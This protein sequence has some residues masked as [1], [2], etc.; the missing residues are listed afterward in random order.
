MTDST[1]SLKTALSPLPTWYLANARRLPWREDTQPYHVWLSEIML[2]QTRVEAVTGYYRRFLAALPTVA[3]LAAV[4]DDMLMK[5]WEGLGYYSRARNLKKAAGV[6]INELGGSFPDTYEGI[7]ALPGVGPYT[8][9]AI[10]SICFGLPEP[11]VDGNVLRVFSRLTEYGENIDTDAAKKQV[12]EAL[13]PCYEAGSCGALTQSLM[14]LGATVCIPN[15][16]PKCGV[17]PVKERCAAYKNGTWDRF[18][19]RGEKKQRKIIYKTVLLLQCGEKYAVKKRPTKGLLAGLWE[20]PN[21]DAPSSE[22][23]TP[24]A[25]A[26]LAAQFGAKPLH[27]KMQT[28]YTHIFTHVEWHMQGFLFACSEMPPAFTWAEKEELDRVYALPSAFSP[29]FALLE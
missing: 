9:G 27:L 28:A 8:A 3:D 12:R 25:A 29:F 21:A 7:L 24:D 15:G 14:E 11:A 6:I 10:A 13:L 17:C 23:V 19:V 1:K 4:D 26:A 2:Q 22:A 16:A 20:F 5:L 18:P